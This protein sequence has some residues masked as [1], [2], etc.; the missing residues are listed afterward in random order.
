MSCKA[1]VY[2]TCKSAVSMTPIM[3]YIVC[4]HNRSSLYMKIVQAIAEK[5]QKTALY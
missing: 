3:L 1:H 2:S 5:L 4:V